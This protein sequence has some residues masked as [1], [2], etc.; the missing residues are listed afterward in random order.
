MRANFAS[1]LETK[2]PESGGRMERH[3]IQDAWSPV[4]SFHSL[5]WFGE[6]CHRLV[7]VHC[8]VHSTQPSTRTFP[9]HFMLPS[10]DKLYGD[11]D[12]IFQQDLH[13]PTLPK[14]PK[15][16]SMTIVSLCNY[17]VISC[18]ILIFWNPVFVGFMSWKPKLCTN[19]QLN[20]WNRLS[21]G[22]WIYNLWKF[23]VLNGIM[24][25]NKLFHDI[26][27]FWKGSVGLLSEFTLSQTKGSV[28]FRPTKQPQKACF[29]L[30]H[31]DP[32]QK[33][34]YHGK[35]NYFRNST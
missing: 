9:E 12:F 24:E 17:C 28:H 23:N 4:W 32:F 13:R 11:A 3:T 31:T 22:P 16:G 5:C 15:P 25:I 30:E 1:H 10:A 21:C 34:E 26:L 7:L 8:A 33:F 29:L 6:P 2:V 20:T 27:I 19:K 35:F 14:E 18:N